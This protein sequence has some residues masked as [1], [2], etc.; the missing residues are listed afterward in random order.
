MP[1]LRPVTLA[2]LRLARRSLRLV[3]PL[4]IPTRRRRVLRHGVATV[5]ARRPRG[6]HV[7]ANQHISIRSWS[8][9]SLVKRITHAQT[10]GPVSIVTVRPER[11]ARAP[12]STTTAFERTTILRARTLQTTTMVAARAARVEPGPAGARG[13]VGR[14][15]PAGPPGR[16][17][18]PPS[19]PSMPSMTLAT[20][21]AARHP[22]PD[23]SIHAAAAPSF[24]PPASSSSPAAT[25]ADLDSLTTQ[26]IRRIER[27]AIAQRERMGDR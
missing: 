1:D 8:N 24:A 13:E 5:L 12:T 19:M 10:G 16:A 25:A 14:T 27:R 4:A 11:A 26:V 7:T 6:L 17:W 21:S 3:K 22:T 20:T 2:R 23:A 15:G 18:V 9:A